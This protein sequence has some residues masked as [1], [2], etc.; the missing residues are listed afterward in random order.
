[1]K[2]GVMGGTFDP[3]HL[4]HLIIAE[5]ARVQLGLARV[6]FIPTGQ[7]WLKEGRTISAA[8]HRLA[9]T[10]LAVAD[11]PAFAVSRLEVDRPGPTYTVETLR[12]LHQRHGPGLELFFILGADSLET[13]PRW[14]EPARV[15]ELSTLVAVPRPGHPDPAPGA[16]EALAPGSRQQLR[17]LSEV[18]VGI[19]GTA[20]RQRVAA[21]L[22]IR[23]WVPRPVEGY[24]AQ[25]GLYRLAP[26]EADVSH[27]GRE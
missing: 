14:V 19:G 26:A 27:G 2:L 12:Q 6:L 3:V 9:M 10:R 15:L 25:H 18:H 23:Y 22:S 17:L 13:L 1:M 7:P 24:I 16:L 8:R 4:G 21:G 20:L 11:N 5:E